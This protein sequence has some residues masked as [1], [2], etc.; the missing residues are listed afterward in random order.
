[1]ALAMSFAFRSQSFMK[2]LLVQ[3]CSIPSQAMHLVLLGSF[4]WCTWIAD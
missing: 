1:M 4:M 2:V 3:G